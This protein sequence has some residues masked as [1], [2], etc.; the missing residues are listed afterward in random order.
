MEGY[1]RNFSNQELMKFQNVSKRVGEVE[2]DHS[3]DFVL[4]Q[5]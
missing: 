1:W 3:T 4:Y 5:M 2:V